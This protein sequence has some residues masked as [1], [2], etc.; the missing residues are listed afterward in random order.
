MFEVVNERKSHSDDSITLP[1]LEIYNDNF[2]DLIATEDRGKRA[3]NLEI[4]K[5]VTRGISKCSLCIRHN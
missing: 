2:R 1:M 5:H 4:R 3:P